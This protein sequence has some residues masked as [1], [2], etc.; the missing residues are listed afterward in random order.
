MV[1]LPNAT[2]DFL[3]DPAI[4]RRNDTSALS[5]NEWTGEKTL[6]C[7]RR[8]GQ[9]GGCGDGGDRL[10]GLCLG[11]PMHLSRPTYSC[12]ACFRAA[13]LLSSLT[14]IPPTTRSPSP[15]VTRHSQSPT[16]RDEDIPDDI[17][18]AGWQPVGNYAVQI[19]W[20]DGFSQVGAGC[21]V[22]G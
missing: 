10:S 20:P 8:G 17:E 4:V 13:C 11:C 18:P 2:K 3:L 1:Q 6:R 14:S 9:G 21:W 7:V 16:C 15:H 5:I 12:C 19:T 22:L